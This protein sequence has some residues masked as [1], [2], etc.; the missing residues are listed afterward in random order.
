MNIDSNDEHL[1]QA[2]QPRRILPVGLKISPRLGQKR[3]I[4]LAKHRVPVFIDIKP[5]ANPVWVRQYPMPLT[6]QQGIVPHIRN[7]LKQGILRPCQSAWN[8]PLFPVKKPNSDDYQPVQDLREV[9]KR[10]TDIHPTVPNL[11]TQVHYILPTNGTQ[12]WI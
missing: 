3:G 9:N 11:Y 8:T 6:S 1:F 4:E 10:V 12:Y 7:L 2:H 5:G